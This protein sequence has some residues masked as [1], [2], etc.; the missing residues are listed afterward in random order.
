MPLY[1]WPLSFNNFEGLHQNE[2]KGTS[3]RQGGMKMKFST[4]EELLEFTENIKGKTFRELD[5]LNLLGKGTKDKG[6]L[7]KIVET[8]FYGYPLNNDMQADF[9]ELGVELKVSGF[10][11]TKKG[12]PS[13]KERISLSKIN[14]HTIVDEEF[15][16]SKFIM[17]NKKLLIIW[18]EYRHGIDYGDFKI[19]DYQ[20]YDM[21]RDEE[22][23]KNDFYII[24]EKIRRGEAHLL[25]EGDTSYLGAA[26][27]GAGGELVT[28]PFSKTLARPRAFSLKNSYLRGILRTHGERAGF[29]KPVAKTVKEYVLDRISPYIGMTQ[30]GIYEKLSGKTIEGRIP[31]NLGKMISDLMIGKDDELPEKDDLF[32]KTSYII[33]NVPVDE[34]YNLVERLSFRNLVISEFLEPWEESGWKQYFEEIT[35]ILICYEGKKLPNG[36]RKLK[37]MKEIT[38]NADDIDNFG[39]SYNMVQN[40]I[41]QRDAS[42]LPYPNS[43]EGQALVIAPKGGKGAEAYKTFFER[44]RTKTCFM[45]EKDFV[46]KKLMEK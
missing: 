31:K 39:K 17:K 7:G 29:A 2:I 45:M 37:G 41:R 43:F 19:W 13:P 11:I 24:R 40:A 22:I 4:L 9:A 34:D 35:I 18:Y 30:L 25:S 20:L 15:E 8:G 33:K 27:K 23:I 1:G 28:Q 5:K 44:D 3:K 21:S 46:K 32:K 10:I 14:Y 38:F 6:V 36:Y 42:L 16:F 12:L 26:T